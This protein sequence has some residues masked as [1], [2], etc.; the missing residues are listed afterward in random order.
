[1]F[2][3]LKPVEQRKVTADQIINRLRPKVAKLPGIALFLQASQD[4]RM[5]GRM[6]KAQYQY[7][8]Q[9]T[10]LNELKYW[11]ATLLGELRKDP[12]CKT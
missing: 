12:C 1:M 2:I 7:A 6:S 8:L 5:G 11:S 3:T 9:S 10:D 4:I